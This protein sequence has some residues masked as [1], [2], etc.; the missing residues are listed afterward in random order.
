[1]PRSRCLPAPLLATSYF[2]FNLSEGCPP[3]THIVLARLQALEA[4]LEEFEIEELL[5]LLVSN[6]Y[7][8]LQ[9]VAKL[10][11]ADMAKIGIVKMG[12]RSA[13]S[14]LIASLNAPGILQFFNYD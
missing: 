9:R 6:G 1:M 14:D 11:D 5:E 4:K 8:S 3:L 12:D 7:A 10:G 2:L 13:L